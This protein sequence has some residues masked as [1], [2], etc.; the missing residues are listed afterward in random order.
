MEIC[1]VCDKEIGVERSFAG[2]ANDYA[3]HFFYEC[4][5]CE[6]KLEV[7]VT[8]EPVFNITLQE[9]ANK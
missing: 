9:E 8:A 7:D 6:A 4:E 1:P 5:H 2:G 3:T